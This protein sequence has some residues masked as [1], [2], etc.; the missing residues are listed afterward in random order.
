MEFQLTFQLETYSRKAL[1]GERYDLEFSQL[2]YN[3]TSFASR[4]HTQL[5]K[6]HPHSATDSTKKAWNA[7]ITSS[8]FGFSYF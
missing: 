5:W 7:F 4:A 2:A 6:Q 8:T 1:Y 3:T